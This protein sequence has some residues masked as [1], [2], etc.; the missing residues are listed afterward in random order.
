MKDKMATAVNM[1]VGMSMMMEAK[2][3]VPKKTIVPSQPLGT[4]RVEHSFYLFLFHIQYEETNR[5]LHSELV[6][7]RSPDLILNRLKCYSEVM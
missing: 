2:M 3:L 7:R 4:H 1:M 6:V 5:A